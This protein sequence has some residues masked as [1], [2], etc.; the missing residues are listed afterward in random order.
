M[1][2][3]AADAVGD[4]EAIAGFGCAGFGDRLGGAEGDLDGA[5]G[6]AGPFLVIVEG[7]W[8]WGVLGGDLGGGLGGGD[9]GGGLGGVVVVEVVVVA[10]AV[11]GDGIGAVARDN[12][13]V[14]ASDVSG[15]VG[16]E[17]GLAVGDE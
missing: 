7:G 10:T 3:A 5:G 9:L 14:Y 4:G 2:V 1:D 12:E 16:A 11:E 17:F 6:G 13:V 8:G 15:F